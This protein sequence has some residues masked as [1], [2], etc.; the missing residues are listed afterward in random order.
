MYQKG[1]K[2][3]ICR[4]KS[5]TKIISDYLDAKDIKQAALAR[6]LKIK[7]SNLWKRMQKSEMDTSF[8]KQVCDALE[9]NFFAD[10]SR[11]YEKEHQTFDVN[12]VFEEPRVPYGSIDSILRNIVQDELKKQKG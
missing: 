11:E 3:S 12:K 6:K 10:L 1:S 2:S 9:H 5:I 8:I 4:V 7:Q